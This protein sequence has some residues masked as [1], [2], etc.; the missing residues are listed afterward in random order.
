MHNL[1]KVRNASV[2]FFG[3]Y[4]VFRTYVKIISPR[5]PHMNRHLFVGGRR[6][7]HFEVGLYL[8]ALGLALFLEDIK[9]IYEHSIPTETSKG[10]KFKR[11][12]HD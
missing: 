9:D 12:I 8:A 2:V 3:T 5:Y 10:L 4:A 6:V 7:H 11:H 1:N